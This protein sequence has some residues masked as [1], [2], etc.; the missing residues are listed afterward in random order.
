MEST[1]TNFALFPLPVILFPGET[2]SLHIFEPRYQ[3]LIRHCENQNMSFGIPFTSLKSQNLGAVVQLDEITKKYPNGESDIVVKATDL[4]SVVQ[5]PQNLENV[6]YPGGTIN[7]ET[8]YKTYTPSVE[9]KNYFQ[10]FL[11]FKG[12]SVVDYIIDN[13]FTV[14]HIAGYL[15]MNTDEKLEFLKRKTLAQKDKFLVN[16]LKILTVELTQEEAVYKGF[17]L[18]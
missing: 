15:Y 3:Q 18:N 12:E 6:L 4:F 2:V 14:Y 5:L 9:L 7:L 8:N 1:R 11:D 13:E 10:K 17:Y 16:Y